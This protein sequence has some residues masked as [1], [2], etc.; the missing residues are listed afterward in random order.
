[1]RGRCIVHCPTQ[2]MRPHLLHFSPWPKCMDQY[3]IRPPRNGSS[4][5]PYKAALKLDSEFT[6]LIL[7]P[8]R[9]AEF[10]SFSNDLT[11]YVESTLGYQVSFIK[12]K[13]LF[14]RKIKSWARKTTAYEE[15]ASLANRCGYWNGTM[16]YNESAGSS[17]PTLNLQQDGNTTTSIPIAKEGRQLG[18][19]TKTSTIRSHVNSKLEKYREIFNRQIGSQSMR[20]PGKL[21]DRNIDY[22]HD[23]CPSSSKPLMGTTSSLSVPVSSSSKIHAREWPTNLGLS[24]Q[25]NLPGQEESTQLWPVPS[26]GRMLYVRIAP[27]SGLIDKAEW[28]YNL[29]HSLASVQGVVLNTVQQYALV[30][31]KTQAD[32]LHLLHLQSTTTILSSKGISVDWSSKQSL[33]DLRGNTSR[34]SYFLPL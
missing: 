7:M 33:Y 6:I 22:P 28:I 31:M 8:T 11:E 4:S 15:A 5:L 30:E 26:G 12:S 34:Y 29:L 10:L 25:A 14:R 21:R 17:T 32:A 24:K 1:M 16:N 27:P 13:S 9:Q 3:I 19:N 20:E 18:Q 2:S 23:Q